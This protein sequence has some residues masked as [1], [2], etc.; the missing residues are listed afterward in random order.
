VAHAP[1]RLVW[2]TDWPHVTKTPEEM[3]NDGDLVDLIAEWIPDEKTRGQILVE[4]PLKL[5]GR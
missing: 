4:N 5:Y 2:A 3:P 1:E